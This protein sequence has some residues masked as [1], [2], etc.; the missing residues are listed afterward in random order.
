MTSLA[1]LRSYA[2]QLSVADFARE[3]GAAALIMPPP[4]GS[5]GFAPPKTTAT[6]LL[7]ARVERVLAML[8]SYDDL[9]VHLLRPDRLVAVLRIGRDPTCDL[10]CDHPSVSKLHAQLS[11]SV[12]RGTFI[13][14]DLGSTNGTAVNGKRLEGTRGMALSDGDAI[15]AGDVEIVFLMMRTLHAQLRG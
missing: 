11:W 2:R 1:I 3:L 5:P 8:R 7:A 6:P 14:T 15:S 4:R 9:V 12:A 13:V 10:I